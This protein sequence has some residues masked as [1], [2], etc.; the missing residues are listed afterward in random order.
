MSHTKHKFGVVVFPGS[1]CDHDA[2][3]ILKQILDQDTC[4]LWHKDNSLDGSDVVILPGGF[5][6]G[7]YLRC[8]AIARFSP[9]MKEVVPF[10]RDGGVVI[11]ICNGFQILCEAGLLPGALLRNECLTFVC[12]FVDFRVEN[13]NTAFTSECNLGEVLHIPIAHGEGNYF[14]DD[15]TLQQLKR[16]GQIL[17]RY[18]DRDGSITPSSNPNGSIANIAGIMNKEGN[19]MG[20]MPHP[21]RAADPMLGYKDGQKIF[22]SV[23]KGFINN[24]QINNYLVAERS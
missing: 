24:E 21:E 9:I 15:A 14:V 12:K 6:Y 23:I 10:A 22:K 4:F 1:N 11:G 19:I 7:D 3:Y 18:C 8:G 20:L 16:N 17:F 13:N 5:S 2:Y